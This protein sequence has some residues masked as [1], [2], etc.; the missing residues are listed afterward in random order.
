MIA[1]ADRNLHAIAIVDLPEEPGGFESRRFPCLVVR[2]QVGQQVE[3][4]VEAAE[5]DGALEH[6][7]RRPEAVVAGRAALAEPEDGVIIEVSRIADPA[8]LAEMVSGGA[9]N[10]VVFPAPRNLRKKL[11]DHE[12]VGGFLDMF[13]ERPP[14]EVV[15]LLDVLVGAIEER[16]IGGHP[17]R[18]RLV[19]DRLTEMGVIVAVEITDIAAHGPGVEERG[20]AK[21]R[22]GQRAHQPHD[23]GGELWIQ[24]ISL[25][26]IGSLRNLL[27]DG[28]LKQPSSRT[29]G[30]K[31]GGWRSEFT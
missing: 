1:P 10:G 21:Q 6:G 25:L 19:R 22:R 5:G 20:C 24:E 23:G 15:D 28:L 26:G 4:L 8:P 13:A 16:D 18:R 29:G 14:A 3:G 30:G 11:G 17:V 31:K 9:G 7:I 12:T 27:A 2:D